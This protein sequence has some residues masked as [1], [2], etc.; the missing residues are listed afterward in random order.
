MKSTV[1]LLLCFIGIA[2]AEVASLPYLSA[3][4]FTVILVYILF[5][6]TRNRVIYERQKKRIDD[7]KAE[8]QKTQWI[9]EYKAFMEEMHGK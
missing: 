1:L 6:G 2:L 4:C 7:I 9:N 8:Q 3:L 5:E